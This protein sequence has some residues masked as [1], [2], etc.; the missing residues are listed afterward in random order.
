MAL[1]VGFQFIYKLLFSEVS[2]YIVF[3]LYGAI[4]VVMTGMAMLLAQMLFFPE[5]RRAVTEFVGN[6][7][8]RGRS[9]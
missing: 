1:L 4:M 6:L 7:F 8:K 2:N 3:G 9:V 5:F